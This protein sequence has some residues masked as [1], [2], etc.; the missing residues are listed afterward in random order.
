MNEWIN[1]NNDIVEIFYER[2]IPLSL[3]PVSLLIAGHMND[4]TNEIYLLKS[5]KK[6]F[7]K[8]LGIGTDRMNALVPICKQYGIIS[9]MQDRGR[10][11]VNP[12][13]FYKGEEE[14]QKEIRI[15]FDTL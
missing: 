11:M 14:K 7:A 12:Y 9:P 5:R 8:I 4:D 15:E 13:L 2:K 10:Y 1:V 3:L 6:Q